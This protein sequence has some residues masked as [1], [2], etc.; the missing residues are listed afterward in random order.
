[1]ELRY[2]WYQDV[3]RKLE[4]LFF[5]LEVWQNAKAIF[6]RVRQDW[7]ERCTSY[8]EAD[9]KKAVEIN[10]PQF[11]QEKLRCIPLTI[12]SSIYAS[13]RFPSQSKQSKTITL[14]LS[15]ENEIQTALRKGLG[16]VR[17]RYARDDGSAPCMG[18]YR[19]CSSVP[20]SQERDSS[21]S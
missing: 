1:M 4:V 3:G 9:R 20:N 19:V 11:R 18:L 2:S 12:R 8:I 17:L 7:M 5:K 14:S 15:D 13:L 16:R 21:V 6:K 10:G